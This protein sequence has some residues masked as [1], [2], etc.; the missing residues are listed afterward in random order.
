MYMDDRT[1]DLESLYMDEQDNASMESRMQMRQT[2]TQTPEG[3][4]GGLSD[5]RA[6]VLNELLKNSAEREGRGDLRGFSPDALELLMACEWPGN[7]LALKNAI[8]RAV[9][10]AP[11]PY[12]RVQD[13]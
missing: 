2:L 8:E 10:L 1:P 4:S 5:Q 12:I 3:Q 13:L 6:A 9:L 11:G 7:M